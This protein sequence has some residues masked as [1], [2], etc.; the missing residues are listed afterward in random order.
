MA[1]VAI[2]TIKTAIQSIL[3]GAN[4]TT[5]SPD[6]SY[7]L[8]D[9]KRINQVL[10]VNVEKILPQPSFF[11][12]VTVFLDT[13]KTEMLSMG[14]NGA[15]AKRKAIL[16]FKVVGI[17]YED[18]YTS[19]LTEPVDEDINQLMENVEEILRANPTLNSNVLNA[20]PTGI[21]YYNLPE[22]QTNFRI[23]IMDFEVTTLY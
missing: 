9:S 3:L 10:K 11:P 2:S 13:K 18:N 14:K 4:T 23:G 5:A 7:N 1:Q 22:E 21:S 16:D 12:C 19:N 15:T 6:L 17:I 20:M 8:I